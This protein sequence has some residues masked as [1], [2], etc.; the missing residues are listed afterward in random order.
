MSQLSVPL[1]FHSNQSFG[2]IPSKCVFTR[3]RLSHAET[4]NVCNSEGTHLRQHHE[5]LCMIHQPGLHA[6]QVPGFSLLQD[7]WDLTPLSVIP[8]PPP[9]CQQHKTQ[10]CTWR[11]GFWAATRQ[12]VGQ[13]HPWADGPQELTLLAP[14]G[15][16]RGATL[17]QPV[18]GNKRRC[19]RWSQPW[20]SCRGL[21]TARWAHAS[22][23]CHEVTYHN[24]SSVPFHWFPTNAFVLLQLTAGI[25]EERIKQ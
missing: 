6:H 10:A 2:G 3:G 20:R 8:R 17:T 16:E 14:A 24:S 9:M 11:T 4:L 15:T 21:S 5:S 7:F 18:W 12:R 25:Q 22:P 19:W 23:S 13:Q 1:Q